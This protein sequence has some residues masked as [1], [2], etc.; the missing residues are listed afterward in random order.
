MHDGTDV[1]SGTSEDCNGNL[2]PDECD[3]ADGASS[4]ANGNGIL[5]ACE[6][7]Q[8]DEFSR[9]AAADGAYADS[10]GSALA[11]DGNVAV[12]GA[13]NDDDNGTSSGSAYVFR[14]D[15]SAWSQR[16]KLLPGD[17]A[18]SDLFGHAVAI[19]GDFVVA[20]ADGDTDNGTN[21]GSAY[22]FHFDGNTW[23]EQAK[24]LPGDGTAG[25]HFGWS[26]A[27]DGDCAII[28]AYTDDDQG[29]DA[30]SAYV[31][32]YDGGAWTEEAKLVASDGAA[33]DCFGVSV[34]LSGDVALIGAYGDSG[35]ALDSG[36]AYVFR[37]DGQSWNE[38]AKLL[39]SDGGHSDNFGW[40]VAIA[41]DTA[42]IGVPRDDDQGYESGAAYVFI[43]DG[44]QWSEQAKLLPGAG[45]EA[46]D[47][48]GCAVATAGDIAVIGARE[49]LGGAR[50]PGAAYVFTRDAFGWFRQARLLA[51]D[52]ALGDR[53]GAAVA[54]SGTVALVGAPLGR[55]GQRAGCRRRVRAPRGL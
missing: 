27:V 9:F 32:R 43:F 42:L 30:G 36:T 34:S 21:S 14:F 50:G 11:L 23:N 4:D 8:T 24:L 53:L 6:G 41:G 37:Y 46:Y 35:H 26:V 31:F 52:G 12:V 17:G 15:G 3:L 44:A 48:F 10:F 40:T 51:S 25:D 22:V 2:R 1:D 29:E 33:L 55:R 47:R 38:E 18:A 5:D 54:V 20:G 28:G 7:C 13:S 19:S 45:G 16:A 49:Y 39:A